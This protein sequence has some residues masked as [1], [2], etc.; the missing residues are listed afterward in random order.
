MIFAKYA[1]S[2]V[3]FLLA[4]GTILGW[5]NEQRIWLYKRTS[6]YLFAFIDTVLKT[7]GFSDAGF[8]IT[9]KVT[10]EE[11]SQRYEKEIMEFGA[12]SPMFTM[13]ATISLVNLFCF[14]GMVKKAV[15]S[16]NGL[17]MSFQTMVLQV[18]LCGILVLINWP[19]YQGLFFRTDKGKMPSSLTIKSFILALATCISFSFLL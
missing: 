14:L 4:G 5:W 8:I 9:A 13:I 19:L 1:A 11:V 6:S 3:E 16:G 2:L 10:D 18:L 7:L 17:V 12:S 15:E